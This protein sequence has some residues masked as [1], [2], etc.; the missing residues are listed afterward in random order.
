MSFT[1]LPS[2]VAAL[3]LPRLCPSKKM[4]LNMSSVWWRKVCLGPNVLIDDARYACCEKWGKCRTSSTGNLFRVTVPLWGESTGQRWIPLAKGQL[5]G[6]WC[7][8]WCSYKQT[9]SRVVGDLRRQDIGLLIVTSLCWWSTPIWCHVINSHLHDA[10]CVKCISEAPNLIPNGNR[11]HP[12]SLHSCVEMLHW[13]SSVWLPYQHR[14]Q[15]E[16]QIFISVTEWK[17]ALIS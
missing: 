10:R 11:R 12:R 4:R 8:L 1:K 5:C 17:V 15:T 2:R 14:R 13:W 6:I 16:R 3:W 9:I 7:F